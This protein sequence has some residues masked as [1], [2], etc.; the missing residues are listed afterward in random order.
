[1]AKIHLTA[2]LPET[3]HPPSLGAVLNVNPFKRRTKHDGN[4]ELA[5][6]ERLTWRMGPSSVSGATPDMNCISAIAIVMMISLAGGV[7]PERH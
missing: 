4:G 3:Q 6:E 1:M 5:A 2:S 7:R